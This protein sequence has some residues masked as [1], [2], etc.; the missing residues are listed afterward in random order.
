MISS[1]ITLGLFKII[2]IGFPMVF[3]YLLKK[4]PLLKKIENKSKLKKRVLIFLIN[5]I[6]FSFILTIVFIIFAYA[7]LLSI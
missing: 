2:S 7:I 4:S 1:K 5:S 6:I 3:G